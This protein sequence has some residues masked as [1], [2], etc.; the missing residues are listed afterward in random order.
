MKIDDRMSFTLLPD[1]TV[2]MR[3]KNKSVLHL[4]GAL[5]KKGR[6]AVSASQLSR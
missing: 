1:G 2:L 4:A 3:A 5:R 6:K